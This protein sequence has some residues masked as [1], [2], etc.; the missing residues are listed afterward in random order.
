ML[1]ES[2]S[3][4]SY[5]SPFANQQHSALFSFFGFLIVLSLASLFESLV[6]NPFPCS[7]LLFITINSPY[8]PNPIAQSLANHSAVPPTSARRSIQTLS[9][10]T[11]P[12]DM[13]S[14]RTLAPSAA[15]W[16]RSSP[17]IHSETIA[18][19]CDIA[20]LTFFRLF[21]ISLNVTTRRNRFA[22]SN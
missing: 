11:L 15:V 20:L 8:V 19:L 9:A 2:P 12:I 16:F 17:L 22:Q 6:A 14:A 4:S 13:A 3:S 1:T 7:D 5:P 10:L 18:R 21:R